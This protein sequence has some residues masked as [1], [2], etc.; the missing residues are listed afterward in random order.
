MLRNGLGHR[1]QNGNGVDVLTALP[2]CDSGDELR[3]VLAVPEAVEAALGAGQPLDDE[4]RVV[5]DEDRH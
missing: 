5:V 2:G 1:V 3:P 4:A